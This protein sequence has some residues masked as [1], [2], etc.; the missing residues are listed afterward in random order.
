[1]DDSLIAARRLPLHHGS[2]V[3]EYYSVLLTCPRCVDVRNLYAMSQYHR[4]NLIQHQH[5]AFSSYLARYG[6]R[7]S[8]TTKLLYTAT[9]ILLNL[10]SVC[11][12]I[13]GTRSTLRMAFPKT[14][15]HRDSD[16]AA[17][18]AS[19][20]VPQSHERD[21]RCCKARARPRAVD[22]CAYT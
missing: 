20:E 21:A 4:F 14:E 22:A 2:T 10:T 3:G 16:A 6:S 8:T 15:A 11:R 17:P 9:S 13:S 12:S 19:C 5:R 7:R 1:M 18:S